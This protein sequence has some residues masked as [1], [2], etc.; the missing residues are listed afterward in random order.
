MMP[1]SKVAYEPAIAAACEY[2]PD[3]EPERTNEELIR[4]LADSLVSYLSAMVNLCGVG[5]CVLHN[6]SFT[7]KLELSPSSVVTEDFLKEQSHD[8]D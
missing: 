5:K 8:K 4:Y 1:D 2:A 3:G 6:Q 7:L